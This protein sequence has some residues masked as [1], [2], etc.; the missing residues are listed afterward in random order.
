MSAH[1][2]PARWKPVFLRALAQTGLVSEAAKHAN[3]TVRTV[4]RARDT[5]NRAGPNLL[6]A[7]TFARDWD[8]ALEQFSDSVELEIKRRAIDGVE[9]ESPIYYKGEQVGIKV[10]RVYSDR[11]LMFLAKALR[12]QRY[13]P[14]WNTPDQFRIA[15]QPPDSSLLDEAR[16]RAKQRWAQLVPHIL[17]VFNAQPNPDPHPPLLSEPDS[18]ND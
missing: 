12:P 8:N 11:L 13:G 2:N 10:T 5:K 18:P 6:E 3:I 4:Q 17:K 7:Q 14:H 9:R 15:N 16:E 1:K